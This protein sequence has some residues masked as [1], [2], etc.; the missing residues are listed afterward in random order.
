MALPA[1]LAVVLAGCSSGG[2]P[3]EEAADF[4]ELELAA[5]DTKGIIRGLVVDDAIRPVAG[6]KVVLQ[7]TPPQEATS[8][9][10][11]L[12]GFE[13][14]EPGTYFLQV[15]RLGYVGAQVSAEVVAGLQEPPIVRVLLAPDAS[16]VVPYYEQFIFEGF[17]ECSA[18]AAAAG[19]YAYHNTCSVSDEAFPNDKTTERHVLSGYPSWVQS[20]MI[21]QS[22][23]SVSRSLSLN[24]HYSD[25]DETDGQKDQSVEGESPLTNTM[26]NETAKEFIEG[27]EYEPGDNLTLRIRI[28]TRAT[29]GTGPALTVQQRFT[30]YTTVF[31]GYLPPAGWTLRES[32]EVPPP[33]Q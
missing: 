4:E 18:G 19:G 31:Y 25:P 21:W 16:F 27:L 20:E 10:E 5:T 24:F 7:A 17:M 23:Q 30:V 8:S 32:G 26:D 15:S 22:T 33:P 13:D 9:A 12:F 2:E 1:V 29:D 6:A 14:L 3:E 11:G 28:F